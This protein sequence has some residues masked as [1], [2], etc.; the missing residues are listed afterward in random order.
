MSFDPNSSDSMFSKI[1]ERLDAQDAMLQGIKAAVDKTNGR[2]S[3]LERW[4]D[5]ITAKTALISGGVTTAL[6]VAAWLID[7]LG[8]R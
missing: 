5:I 4:R 2:V 1:L 7:H 8:G 6:G 3:G